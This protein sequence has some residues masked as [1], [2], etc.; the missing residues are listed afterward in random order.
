MEQNL[1]GQSGIDK[2]DG[3]CGQLRTGELFA[4]HIQQPVSYKILPLRSQNDME[5]RLF[6][7]ESQKS[8]EQNR[9]GGCV[10]IPSL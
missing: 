2:M 4:D 10:K 5:Q 1:T 6:T 3:K 7:Y 8:G 9:Y